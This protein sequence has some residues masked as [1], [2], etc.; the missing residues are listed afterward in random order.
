MSANKNIL[1]ESAVKGSAQANQHRPKGTGT[2]VFKAI[3]SYLR[4]TVGVSYVQIK[5]MPY[6]KNLAADDLSKA[7]QFFVNKL[8]FEIDYNS[9]GLAYL[10]LDVN[11]HFK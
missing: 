4:R 5:W 3:L 11:K 7:T 8:H 10:S 9:D 1:D 6:L 2:K